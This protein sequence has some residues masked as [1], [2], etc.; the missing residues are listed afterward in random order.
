MLTPLFAAVS[1]DDI[2][3]QVPA[4]GPVTACSLLLQPWSILPRVE[5]SLQGREPRP[6]NLLNVTSPTLGKG[7]SLPLSALVMVDVIYCQIN[8]FS[9]KTENKQINAE[10]ELLKKKKSCRL[11]HLKPVQLINPGRP[12]WCLE[13]SLE[14]ILPFSAAGTSL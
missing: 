7:C 14:L 2:Y 1:P 3:L 13:T 10:P 8:V 4:R 5:E 9:N 6:G 11:A 12:P